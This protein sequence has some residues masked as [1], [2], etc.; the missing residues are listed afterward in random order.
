MEQNKLANALPIPHHFFDRIGVRDLTELAA[1]AMREG[2]AFSLVRL[3]DG[4]G[5]MLCW[6]GYQVPGEMRTV[7]N[8][9]FGRSDLP[10]RALDIMADGLRQAVRSADVLGLPTRFQL[11]RNPRYEI[12]FEGISRYD[13]YLPSQPL[14]D[15]GMHWYLQWS[16]ALAYLLRNRDFI[17]VIGCRDIGPQI[18]EALSIRSVRT[19]LVRGENSFPGSIANP[20]WPDGFNEVMEHLE[21]VRP[22]SVFLVGAGILGK[23]YC[24]RIKARGGIALDIGS[25]LD[26][27]ANVPSRARFGPSAFTLEH[28]RSIGN[29]WEQ[30]TTALNRCATELNSR[31][32]TTML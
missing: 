20:H 14:A 10:D 6:P 22:G 31:N 16:G 19:Y 28:L 21:S 9:W 24:D 32:T 5:P 4:E 25:I 26:S 30:M 2:R 1:H 27:W 23:L 7:L 15:C 11:T 13:L 17:S 18:A 3:G 12:V 8:A 29:D